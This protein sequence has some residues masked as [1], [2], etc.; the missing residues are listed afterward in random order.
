MKIKSQTG[1]EIRLFGF[2]LTTLILLALAAGVVTGLGIN[3]LGLSG[4]MKAAFVDGVFKVGGDVFFAALKMLVVPVVFVSIVCGVGALEDVRRMG[5]IGLKS[6]V[7]YIS[8]TG[9]AIT[10]ALLVSAATS[11][12]KGFDLSTPSTFSP[13]EPPGIV[14]TIIGFVPS[15]PV[16]AMAKADMIQVIVLALLFGVALSMAKAPGKRILGLFQDLNEV[17]MKLVLIVMYIAPI[18]VFCL[19]ASVFAQQ[20]FDAI[21]PL[22]K[23]FGTVIIALALHVLITYTSILKFLGGLSP[24]T[25]F[26]KFREVMV[27]AFSTS[28][29]TATLPVNIEVTEERLGVDNSVASFTLPLGATINMDGT[30]IMQ[31]VAT[32]FISQAYGVEIGISGYVMVILTATLA[33]I[34]TAGVP[35]VGLITLAMVLKQVNLPV[36]GIGLIIGVDRILDM[37]RTVVNVI[38][39]SVITCVVAKSEDKMNVETFN[40]AI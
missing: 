14:D 3:L 20:G 25:F 15:N 40:E 30:A 35:G 19:L 23:Y 31:G 1:H 28:S 10:L 7:L 17:V 5:R 11:P 6:F 29:S 9:A 39:D 38:G 12:G 24:I 36:E 22:S 37:S 16:Q 34:G 4:T 8:S 26:K 2:T 21:A 13:Q 33:S 32:V 27:F 18:G